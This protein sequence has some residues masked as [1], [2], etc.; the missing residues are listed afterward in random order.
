MSSSDI[1]TSGS[2]KGLKW[3]LA[4]AIML[5]ALYCSGWFYLSAQVRSQFDRALAG[6]NNDGV[7]AQC[8]GRQI[9]GFP[10][11][12]DIACDALNYEDA[13][14][15]TYG[16]TGAVRAHAHIYDPLLAAAEIDGPLRTEAPNIIPLWID[17]EDLKGDVRYGSPL[18]KR[19]FLHVT[20]LAGQTDP[21]DE[22]NPEELFRIA[23]L[24]ARLAP[25]GDNVL[26]QG[27]F[28]GLELLPA[29]TNDRPVPTLDGKGEVVLIDGIRMIASRANSF[30]GQ[31]LEF[32]ALSLAT[33]ETSI[34]LTGP[35][36]IGADGLI[37]AKFELTVTNPQALSKSLQAAVPEHAR[38]IN[39]GL[40]AM[41]LGGKDVKLQLNI[42]KGKAWLGPIPLGD[43]PPLD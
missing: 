18:P 19:V 11:S 33:G 24:N 35:V 39:M 10:F 21:E 9:S 26:A 22:A 31:S 37:D 13:G 14:K 2:R 4:T 20:K 34:G 1:R 7:I 28:S 15:G 30:R 25:D 6:L 29:A 3:L 32:R 17:W 42:A 23:S 12:I 43:I 5:V 41:A 36:T 8:T 16:S 40:A 38:E 27:A